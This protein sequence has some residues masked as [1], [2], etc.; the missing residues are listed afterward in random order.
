MEH[1]VYYGNSFFLYHSKSV[2]KVVVMLNKYKHVC[3]ICGQTGSLA[4]D[5]VLSRAEYS[6]ASCWYSQ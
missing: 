3:V 4:T 5:N 6:V 2:I 1:C